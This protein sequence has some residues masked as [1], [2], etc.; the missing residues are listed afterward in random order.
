M[1]TFKEFITESVASDLAHKMGLSH[2]G[3]GRFGSKGKVSHI[4]RHGKLVHISKIT[5]FST[6]HGEQLKHLE[7]ADDEVFN[8]GHQGVR[9]VV[10]HI[11]AMRHGDD[12]IKVGTKFDGSP[13]L[14][15]GRDHTGR[16]WVSTK[17]A[18]NK[19][20]KINYSEKDIDEN[21]GH[22][23][24]LASK[25]K[26]ALRH[27]HKLGL[28]N[29]QTLQADM[30]YDEDDKHEENNHYT[31]KPNTIKYAVDKHS[32]EGKKIE[33]SKIGLA[34]HTEYHNGIAHLNPDVK[35][36]DHPDI[37]KA[38]VKID[39]T[40]INFDENKLRDHESHIGKMLHSLSSD[41][42][43]HIQ[44]PE[45][46]AHVKTYINSKIRKGADNYNVPE[47]IAHIHT[48]YQ[49]EIDAAKSEKGK[50][51]KQTKRDEL[52]SHVR[53]NARAYKTAFELQHHITQAKHHII[54]K[55]NAHQNETFKHSYA[56]GE[57]ANP[58]GYVSIGHHGPL[59]F[60]NRKE[61]SR[62]NFE[63]SANRK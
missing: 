61:F 27:I 18:F 31:F 28:S 16:H 32:T 46:R 3:F 13:S 2:M 45:V 52:L 49:T 41:D 60:V 9:N 11:Q 19:N 5:D 39:H 44:H 43:Q 54:D 37:Y 21:H 7:H 53:T 51:S 4:S 23:P 15:F 29:G 35:T 20:P 10:D 50:I 30:M 48:K 34:I 36:A 47:L 62:A 8:N 22:A 24:G 42:W 55:L 17:S 6:L 40:K 1:I 26:S 63:Q 33:K 25:L 12:R 58:E 59:K 14:T 57:K 56:N 38:P